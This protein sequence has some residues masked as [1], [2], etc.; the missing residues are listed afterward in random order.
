[1]LQK[2]S[3]VGVRRV[4]LLMV[5]FALSGIGV[6][7]QSTQGGVHGAVSDASGAA[8][9]SAKVTLTNEGTN[10]ARTAVTN[11]AGFYDFSN[12]VPATYSVIA[13]SPSF[14]K[15][16]RKNVLV[17]TQEYVT[18]DIRLEVGNVTE[19]VLVTE[20]MP[21]VESS[22]A[23]QGQV[24]DNQKLVDLPNLGRNPFMMSRLAQNVVQVGPP[25]YNRMEDQ[26]GSSEISIAGGPVRGN[27]YLLDG[28]PITDANN[29]AI[30]IPTLEA[31]QEVKIQ[32]NTYDAEMA[33]TGGGMFNTLMKSGTNDFHGSLYGHVRRTDWDANAFFSNAAA[34]PIAD[35]PNT[36]WG[37]SFGGRIWIPKVY[38]GK[39][40]TFFFLGVEHYD[41]R[42]SD[43]QAFNLPTQA[44]T[45]GNFS[46]V[47]T[48]LTSGALVPLVINNPTTNQPFANNIIP[49][50]QLSPVGLAIASYYP[51][52]TSTPAYYGANDLSLSSSIKARA[53]QYT[54]KIDED[55][56]SWWR[57]SLS[58]LRYYSLEPGDTWFNSPSTQSGWR[59]LRRV[60]AT[61]L[62]NLFTINPTT[63]VAV[64]YGFNR[65][66]NF[67]YNSSQGFNVGV[68]GMSPAYAGSI[69]PTIAEFPQIN[70]STIY[71]LGDSG[72]WDYYD[73]ASHNFSVSVD[74]FIGK[75][76]IKAGFDYR[77]LATSGSGINCTTGC[78]S[79]NTGTVTYSG[80]D[81]ADLLLGAPYTRQADT[82][83]TL[84]DYIHYYAGFVQDNFRLNSKITVNF[85]LRLEHESGVEEAHNG[86]IVNFNTAA[87]NPLAGNGAVEYAGLNGSPTHVGN[88]QGVKWGPR[89]GVAY[90]L[91][92]KTVVRGGY[93][94][95]Y[96]PQI[97]L[98][99]PIATPGYAN[100]T[101]Y[102]GL[103]YAET[104]GSLYD[105]FPNGLNPPAGNSAGTATDIGSGFSLVDPK[106]KA[107]MIQQYSIDVQRELKGGIALEVG[108]VGS[109]STHLT[110]GNP[111]ININALPTSDLAQGATAL[112]AEVANPFAGNPLVG[113]GTLAG[114]TQGCPTGVANCISAFRLMLPY[115][116]YTEIEQ[117]YGDQNHASYNSM[118]IKAQKRFSH[119]LTFLSTLTLSRNR[120][121]SSGGVGSFLNQGAQ[122]APQNPYNTAAEYSLSN[123]DTPVRLATAIT[124]ELPVGKGKPF[125]GNAN[126]LVDLAVGGWSVNAVSVY[127][128][129]FPLQVY[130]NDANSAYGYDAQRPN[131][132]GSAI[133][134]SGSVESRLGDYINTAAFSLAGPATF[135]NTP[136][137]L[138][139][140]RGPGQKNWDLSIFKNFSFSERAKAQFRAEALNAFNSP[141]FLAPDTNLSNGDFGVIS[142][143][144]NFSRQLQLAIRFTF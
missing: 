87:T 11:S 67:D 85:G 92:D 45:V 60:D 105:P 42:S 141:L 124:Y 118:V 133:T 143:Q 48:R 89:G 97:A 8:V 70:M 75:H 68:L 7:A 64:R 51:A 24:L 72:D 93:G 128:T 3:S 23:S 110:L 116:A 99:G 33:R 10:E 47:L 56:T 49:A 95:F 46:G 98:G 100:N 21:L 57:S 38:D 135:G 59:L 20:Q 131:L 34:L 109:H 132:T 126:R 81:L 6:W 41:D 120:D 73:E 15:F 63:V 84:T 35:Q 78:Y 125:L 117:I 4:D 55:F 25:A 2:F 9:P 104:V 134:T 27:N 28:I 129:G 113:S 101:Q 50:S 30:I 5:L 77:R 86:L 122:G 83:S 40:K 36:T 12:V 26:S 44:E 111:N 139:S 69:S 144:A 66:P 90:Q 74:K 88:Y 43:S 80:N 71:G 112:N 107:P 108:Y 119:G 39:N 91:N 14:K 65:F 142:G 37:G 138:G 102:T 31:V 115:P 17:G 137:T 54:A 18:V 29:R 103:T 96:A 52:P 62:N 1:M 13:E 136:R 140:L 32:S 58:Y 130:Q 19:S 114:S 82:S 61:Q 106:T 53:V 94:I 121:E 22:N 79:F 76:S 127:Q 16:E 123:V